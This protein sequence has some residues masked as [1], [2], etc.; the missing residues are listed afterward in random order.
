M[1]RLILDL[2]LYLAIG[3]LGT[4]AAGMVAGVLLAAALWVAARHR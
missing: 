1:A 3:A 4:C 2:P